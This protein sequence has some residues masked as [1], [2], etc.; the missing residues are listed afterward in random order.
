MARRLL[1]DEQSDL[2]AVLDQHRSWISGLNTDDRDRLT[3]NLADLIEN[4]RL[5]SD[6]GAAFK[7]RRT[8][9][10]GAERIVINAAF[11]EKSLWDRIRS[12]FG[13]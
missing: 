3:K 12:A 2:D 9:E 11:G 13:A 8:L 10:L 1:L 4:G 6:Q 5:M 7:S